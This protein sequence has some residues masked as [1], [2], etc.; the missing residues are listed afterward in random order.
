MVCAGAQE[1]MTMGAWGPGLFADDDAADLREDY[2]GFLADAQSDEG[3]T[4][5]AAQDY[6]AS[7]ERP[8]DT[9]AFWLALASIQWRIGRLDPRVK[10]AAV[11][12]I[13]DGLDLA[14][15]ESEPDRRKRAAVLAKLR[16]TLLTPP[17]PA[18][19]LPKPL[20]VQLP[21][22]EF[23]E[24]VGYRAANGRYVLLHVL[25]YRGWSLPSARAPIVTILNWFAATAPNADDLAALTYINHDGRIGGHHVMC[26]AMPRRT[27][28]RPEQFDRPGWRKPV[29]R[30]EATS[31]IYGLAGHEGGTLDR[32]LTKVLWPYWEDP[33]RPVHVPKIFPPD[34]DSATQRQTMDELRRRL[35]GAAQGA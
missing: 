21:G 28:L 31:A 3:A 14:K 23:S 5:A 34:M 7:L 26:L 35:F 25:G 27:A 15:W 1:G 22:W 24:V 33:T 11:T 16:A 2:R 17:P 4:D 12:I 19:P 6:G 20:P 13:D 10:A 9:T 30:G 32:K 18:R 29:T 8:G